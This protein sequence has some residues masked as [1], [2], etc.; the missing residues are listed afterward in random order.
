[1]PDIQDIYRKCLQTVAPVENMRMRQNMGRSSA[2]D[3]AQ[4]MDIAVIEM[5][6]RMGEATVD[7]LSHKLK[8]KRAAVIGHLNRLLR[9]EEV[10]AERPGDH[11][12]P[13]IWK[14]RK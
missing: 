10:M 14:V 7:D 2:E 13:T 1:M 5:L 8:M 12:M 3:R 11:R 9:H 6:N 4:T